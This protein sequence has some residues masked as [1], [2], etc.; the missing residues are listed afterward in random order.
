[1]QRCPSDPEL[2]SN[3]MQQASLHNFFSS[4]SP[5]KDTSSLDYIADRICEK[6]SEKLKQNSCNQVTGSVDVDTHTS[7]ARNLPDFL[8]D[9]QF[10]TIGKNDTWILRCKT[11][12][13]YLN[14]TVAS[15]TLK[16]KHTGD[17]LA[18]GLTLSS[19]NYSKHCPGNCSEWCRLKHQMLAHL[20]GS[21]KTH[22]SSSLFQK[23]PAKLQSCK[24]IAIKNQLRSTVVVVQTKC[25]AIHYET[26][27]AE[28][29]Q[30]GADVADFGHSRNLFPQMIDVACHYIDR[31][32][33]EYLRTDLPNTGLPPHYYVSVDKSTNHRVSNQVTMLCSIV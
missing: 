22:Q 6:I 5:N 25:A 13:W 9:V 21:S 20:S 26:K 23:Q 14:N 27:I 32:T 31:E 11:C 1:M 15:S 4:V 3:E 29:H 10:E 18:T 16:H 28:L 17:S 7:E 2:R 8:H 24:N 33:K 19:A 30:A 12:Y